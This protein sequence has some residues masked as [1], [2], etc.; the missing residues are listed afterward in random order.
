MMA[1]DPQK[2]QEIAQGCPHFTEAEVGVFPQP[3]PSGSG[4][5][6][7]GRRGLRCWTPRS[8]WTYWRGEGAGASWQ[9]VHA[10]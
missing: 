4:R 1:E 3:A 10:L 5:R 2:V 6:S 9:W 7:V 8:W